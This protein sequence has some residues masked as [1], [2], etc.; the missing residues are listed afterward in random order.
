MEK[1]LLLLGLLR[2]QEMHGY[3]LND[4]IDTSLAICVD[5]KK[6][7]AYYLLN[8]MYCDGWITCKEERAG[9]RPPRRVYTITPAGEIAFQRML[10]ESLSDY[11][12]VQFRGDISLAFLDSLPP[13]ETLS[14]LRKRHLAI[15]RQLQMAQTIPIHSSSLQLLIEHQIRH[16]SAELDWLDEVITRIESA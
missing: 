5:L 11:K 14:L 15:K 4:F 2:T 3:Q 6:P 7:T 9:N 16:L 1:K 12:P 10:R 8:K 13:V